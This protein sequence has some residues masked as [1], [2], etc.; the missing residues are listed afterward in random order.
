M[1]SQTISHYRIL[2]KLGE[3]GMGI[4]YKAHDTKLE[5][6][7]A[8]KF[9]P[10]NL[11]ASPE[12][13]ARFAQEARAISALNHPA[14]E[15]IFD[16]DEVDG[17]RFL[18]LEYIPG[19]TVK[20]KLKRLRSEDKQFSIAEVVEYGVQIADGLAHAHRNQII[21]RDVKTENMMLTADGKIKITD[22]GLA[23]LRGNVHITKSGSTVGTAAYMSP[24]Q[25]RGE[26]IDNRSDI[27]SFGIVL[28]ELLTSHL[29]FRGEFETALS[30]SIL[31]EN[32]PPISSLRTDVPQ[33]LDKIIDRCLEKD[34][35]KRYEHAEQIVTELKIVQQELTGTVKIVT[36]H[37]KI[38]WFAAAAVVVIAL[39][40]IYFFYPKTAVSANAKTIAV[41]PFGNL[42]GNPDD[43][44]FSDGMMEDIHTNLSKIAD[45]EVIART[46]VEQYRGTKKPIHEI[47]RELGAGVILEGIVRH[48]GNQ[49]KISAQL[50]NAANDKELWANTYDKEYKDIFSIQSDVA[51]QIASALNA[52]LSPAEKERITKKPTENIEA[53]AYYLKA[54]ENVNKTNPEAII[55]SQQYLRKAIALDSNFA[56][57]IATLGAT[58]SG[59]FVFE[60]KMTLLDTALTFVQKALSLDPNLPEG[61]NAMGIISNDSGNPGRAE[62]NYKKALELNPNFYQA[63]MNLGGIYFERSEYSKGI[64]FTKEA[65]KLAPTELGPYENITRGFL[66]IG[67]IENARKYTEILKELN[68]KSD[69]LYTLQ[70]QIC[71]REGKTKDA[72]VF[73]DSAL[74]NNPKD[75]L[76]YC[77]AA[78]MRL[79][80]GD[81]NGSKV[82]FEKI[83]TAD[84]A[85][86]SFPSD[87]NNTTYLGY[88]YLKLGKRD[89]AEKLFNNSVKRDFE[90]MKGSPKEPSMPYDLAGIFAMRGNKEEGYKWLEEAVKKGFID[91][92]FALLE[93]TFE[94]IRNEK[95]FQ[96]MIAAMKKSSEEQIKSVREM[97]EKEG[98]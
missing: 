59:L 33:G 96:D 8:L 4:V 90:D 52:K 79:L 62:E 77:F 55:T 86:F 80:T 81:I 13:I 70:A 92:R 95:R 82:Y 61:Y 54:R 41:L 39:V 34:K 68:S 36:R 89:F 51:Q 11:S 88:I 9:L 25:I 42:S 53:Y 58:Y 87:I 10:E 45:L 38:P 85:A 24:E 91:Y 40:C 28:Y 5:R 75:P 7:V 65:L 26:E 30:Y 48:I 63:L 17:R 76:I 2:E 46:S 93:P 21:H 31:N 19:G 32:A 20:S 97:E 44:Y 83:V 64:R 98:R 14:V 73:A 66:W 60:H 94:N 74:S 78:T 56:Q 43:Q 57:A 69:Q 49:V 15:T 22:F 67:D 3:G 12:D 18:V 23:K 6:D 37:S 47:G 84:S 50:I 72:I 1:I 35:A 27:F 16:V 29:P 71:L